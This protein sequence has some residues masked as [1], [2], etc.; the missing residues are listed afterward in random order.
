VLALKSGVSAEGVTAYKAVSDENRRVSEILVREFRDLVGA[1]VV[2]VGCG[3]GDIAA[4]AWPD[5]DVLLVDV[6][7]YPQNQDAPRH[8]RVQADFFDEEWSHGRTFSTALLAHVLQYIDES[9]EALYRRLVQLEPK[10]IITVT[11]VY[12]RQFSE[13]VEW[14]VDRLSP[15][16]PEG[17]EYR[18]PG[19]TL[20]RE[21]QFD[22][23]LSADSFSKLATLLAEIV[24]DRRLQLTEQEAFAAFLASRLASPSIRLRQ[25]VRGYH[26]AG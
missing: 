20:C 16:N 23:I 24:L 21:R 7:P 10:S 22:G 18:F 5:R 9:P 12:D 6:L 17:S 25:A 26:H 19:Y 2:D 14:A 4:C 15:I 3:L 1:T 13:I 11:D 8:L